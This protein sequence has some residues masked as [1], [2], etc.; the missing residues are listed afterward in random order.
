MLEVINCC[1]RLKLKIGLIPRVEILKL[2]SKM[3][4]EMAASKA[5][6]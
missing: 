4:S 2:A 5:D 6:K 1:K 3:A